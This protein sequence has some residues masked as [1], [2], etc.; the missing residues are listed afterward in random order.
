MQTPL[1]RGNSRA[2]LLALPAIMLGFHPQQSCVVLALEGP[3][4]RFCMRVNL[5]WFAAD[6]DGIADQLL[7][8]ADQAGAD[9]FV[10]IGFGD[11]DVASITVAELVEVL[12]PEQ[13]IEALVADGGRY[14]SM[15][16][17]DEAVGYRFD[18]STVAAQAVYHGVNVCQDR[19]SAVAPVTLS[20]PP[21]GHV[22]QAAERHV[23]QLDA[24]AGMD[25]LESLAEADK[26]RPQ[27]ALLL[28]VLLDDE[29]RFGELLNRLRT[30]TAERYWAR[31]VEA[32]AVCPARFEAN[33]LALLAVASW[34]SG[35]G[36]AQTSCLEQL[37]VRAPSHPV[38]SMLSRLHRDGVPP[39][40]WDE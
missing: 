5:D 23:A 36:A 29:A 4:V 32:R 16:S 18:T 12:G 26:I 17:P 24:D 38:L 13:V 21:A 27:D 20:S 3:T 28:A 10:L 30:W 6:F 1:I 25:L 35:R 8:A 40:L 33:V 2:D 14:W 15:L 19:D 9:G 34:L 7:N 22:I 11:P 39:R 31:L 37:S